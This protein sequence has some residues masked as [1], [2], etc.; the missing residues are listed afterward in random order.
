LALDPAERVATAR[1]MALELE[2]AVV[3][4]S[5]LETSEWVDGLVGPLLRTRAQRISELESVDIGALTLSRSPSNPPARVT[6]KVAPS[7]AF[8][9]TVAM[10]DPVRTAAIGLNVTAAMPLP[11]DPLLPARPVAPSLASPA[12]APA[13]FQ[14]ATSGLS[15]VSVSSDVVNPESKVSLAQKQR[16][17]AH[18]LLVAFPL[19]GCAA[20]AGYY[21][22]SAN[23]RAAS[24]SR[25]QL[26]APEPS[27]R[28]SSHAGSAA[29]ETASL[30]PPPHDPPRALAAEVPLS[31]ARSVGSARVTAGRRLATTPGVEPR[32]KPVNPSSSA[33]VLSASTPPVQSALPRSGAL[34]RRCAVPFVVD[35]HGVK[36]FKPE[37][38]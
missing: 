25:V 29:T 18:A 14:S 1:E 32:S 8:A 15:A 6:P 16:R 13:I 36:R 10:S 27:T 4:A 21:W 26:S 33:A 37:C 19:V 3:P 20:V 30:P 23:Q 22:H 31:Q 38:F 7:P 2:R 11:E 9:A 34:Q 17:F 24:E 5:T 35:E 12:I 28:T